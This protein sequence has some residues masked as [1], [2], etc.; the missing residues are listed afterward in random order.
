MTNT[1]E[2]FDDNNNNNTNFDNIIDNEL[3]GSTKGDIEL[4][5][6]NTEINSKLLEVL[7]EK[8]PVIRYQ[9]QS[10]LDALYRERTYYYIKSYL[11]KTLFLLFLILLFTINLISV[12]A[13]LSIN[14]SEG[15]ILRVVGAIYAF[16][17]SIIYLLLN[18]KQYKIPKILETKTLSQIAICPN[19]PFKFY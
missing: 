17:F 3:G 10:E 5:K 19:D 8:D 16:F 4:N 13:S 18:Y 14:R 11:K 6:I 9:K 12:A 1:I 15:I 7:Q 2:H